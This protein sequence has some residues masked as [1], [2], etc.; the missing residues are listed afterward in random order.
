MAAGLGDPVA[1]ED[2]AE[3]PA[4]AVG[5]AAAGHET[6]RPPYLAVDLADLAD[7][8]VEMSGEGERDGGDEGAAAARAA[9][10]DAEGGGL[11]EGVGLVEDSFRRG[12]EPLRA[13]EQTK[14]RVPSW[15]RSECV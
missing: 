2:P 11:A 12:L 4:G 15:C 10:G 9:A 3:A 8:S 6:G 14:R 1:M 7:L 5:E 13:Y